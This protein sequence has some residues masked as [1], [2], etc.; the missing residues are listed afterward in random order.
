MITQVILAAESFTTDVA[1][2]RPFVGVRA[3]VNQQIVRLSEMSTAEATDEL[4]SARNTARN[5]S[6]FLAANSFIKTFSSH[7]LSI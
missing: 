2:V 7:V 3:F 1:L 6:N 4:T 5:E